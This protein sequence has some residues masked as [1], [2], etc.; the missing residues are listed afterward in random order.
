MTIQEFRHSAEARQRYWA[1]SYVGWQRFSAA[2]ANPAHRAVAA[3]QDLGVVGTVITQNVDGLH[4]SAG[5]TEVIELHGNLA[6]VVC[7]SCHGEMSRS[8]LDLLLRRANPDFTVTS[9]EI[10]PDGDISLHS[11][12]VARFH[13]P[14]CPGCGG[15]QLRPDVVFFGDSVP[16]H[17]VDLCH[18][19]VLESC[20]LL[21]LGSSLAVMSGLRFVR[22]ASRQQLPVVIMTAGPS[23]GD[24]LAT[25][26]CHRQLEVVLPDVVARL[27]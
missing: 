18:N 14:R 22:Q 13:G 4:Q 23:R 7:D 5:A 26:R 12:D 17:R 11:V 2:G 20:G 3:L 16:R 27:A 10:R 9:D 19:R 6:R 21:V 8:E 25:L 24:E 15:D 1:R